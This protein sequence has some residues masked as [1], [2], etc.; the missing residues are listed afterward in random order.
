ML[1][2][3]NMIRFHD[4]FGMKETLDI[5]AEAGIEGIDF[6]NDVA[7]FYTAEHDGAYYKELADYAREKGIAVS[8][9]HAP[10]PTSYVEEE[11]TEK[12][13]EELVQAIKNASCFGAPMTVVHPRCHLVYSEGN[14]ADLLFEQ[15]VD[16]YKRLIPYAREYGVKIA[17]ENIGLDTVTSAPERLNKLFDTLN[18]PVFTV[19][20]D[21][22]H[23]LLQKVDPA[24]AIRRIGH[25]MT[26]GCTHFHDNMGD[27]DTHTLPYY[28]KVEWESVMKALAEIGYNGN[29]SYEA[30]GFIAT[31]PTELRPDG[32]K[33][34]ARVGRY[35]IKRFEYHKKLVSE[36][37]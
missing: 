15:N 7:E 24:D 11:K 8:Q 4:A 21:V 34:M 30:S 6:N 29:L 2:S 10:F 5:F 35:L 26:D 32:L 19:C 12:R 18:D 36:E 20:F 25:R 31:V 16:M 28:G 1:L 14:N 9:A 22:G 17:I 27:R 23:C 13:F 37:V 33:Y 3:S